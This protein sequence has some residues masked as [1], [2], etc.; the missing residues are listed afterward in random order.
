MSEL[1][2]GSQESEEPCG[3]SRE[4]ARKAFC[5]KIVF[6]YLKCNLKRVVSVGILRKRD[7]IIDQ[8]LSHLVLYRWCANPSKALLNKWQPIHV[9]RELGEVV[10]DRV[11]DRS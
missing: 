2:L 8:L 11:V 1:S 7:C 9:A 6:T 5:Q 4:A 10:G 3:G